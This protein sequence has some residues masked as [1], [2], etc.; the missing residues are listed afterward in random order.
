MMH[1]RVVFWIVVG[2][3][4]FVVLSAFFVFFGTGSGEF[5]PGYSGITTPR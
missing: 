1:R 5:G 2:V 3:T 4:V